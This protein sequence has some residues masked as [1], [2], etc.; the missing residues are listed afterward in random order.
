MCVSL[1]DKPF[2]EETHSGGLC[3]QTHC[4]EPQVEPHRGRQAPPGEG[5]CAPSTAPAPH[6]P[7]LPAN[8]AVARLSWFSLGFLFHQMNLWQEGSE[9]LRTLKQVSGEEAERTAE[10]RQ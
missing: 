2:G 8:R 6:P 4:R 3:F 10:M 7:P 9:H 1:A 5:S